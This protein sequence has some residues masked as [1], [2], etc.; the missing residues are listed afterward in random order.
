MKQACRS[1][2]WIF[3]DEAKTQIDAIRRSW[4]AEFPALPAALERVLTRLVRADW[5]QQ[6]VE[7][8]VFE[9]EEQLEDLSAAEW[10]AKQHQP[11]QLVYRYHALAD[12]QFHRAWKSLKEYTCRQIIEPT[13]P[14]KLAD[15]PA[16]KPDIDIPRV[17]EEPVLF[18]T[19][20]VRIV[21]GEAVTAMYPNNE[22]E[23]R[24][25]KNASESKRAIRMFEFPDGVPEE[26][27]WVFPEL[28]DRR[29]G[30][31]RQVEM[32]AKHWIELASRETMHAEP[33]PREPTRLETIRRRL[34]DEGKL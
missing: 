18:Q 7:Q 19:V 30:A 33:C 22:E 31:R 15:K 8:R 12:R 9:V 5:R 2:R 28:E 24:V 20:V 6:W 32:S 23:M 1:D 16:P 4:E 25:G 26:Y 13:Q 3:Q 27:D 34:K 10:T 29:P 11:L 21:D 17:Y 14:D